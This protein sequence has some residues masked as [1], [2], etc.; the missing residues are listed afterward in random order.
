MRRADAAAVARG[1]DV[2]L[3]RAAG[4]ALAEAIG[5]V[6]PGARSLVAFAGPGNNGGDA[7]AA[8]AA[9]EGDAR[10]TI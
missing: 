6:A 9:Y 5:V 10:G 7:Y 3:M 4:E 1:G 8:F 2:V